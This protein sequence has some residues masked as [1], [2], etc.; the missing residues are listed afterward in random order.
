MYTEALQNA[1]DTGRATKSAAML[2]L[3]RHDNKL[4]LWNFRAL[5]RLEM[6]DS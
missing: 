4:R 3:R 5:T 2:D 6:L 1:D